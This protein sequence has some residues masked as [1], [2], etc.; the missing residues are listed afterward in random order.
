MIIY[1]IKNRL[2]SK[3]YVGMTKR[4]L[5]QCWRE[6]IRNARVNKDEMLIYSAIRKYGPEAFE[7]S[8]LQ[9]CTTI[10]EMKNAEPRWIEKLG[11]HASLGCGYNMTFG[12]EGISGYRHTEKTKK[13]MSEMRRGKK[14]GPMS[15]ETKRNIS[16][17][18][19]GLGT[20]PRLHVRGWHHSEEARTKISE[21]QYVRVVQYDMSGNYVATYDSMIAAEKATGIMRQGISRC[22]RF[23]RR[24]T[25]GFRFRYLNEQTE[26]QK[27]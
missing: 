9:E 16:K 11:T 8:M 2:N 23:S 10:E 27:E 12:G 26:S 3:A 14:F 7:V 24:S 21:S 17:A 1:L 15:E 6:H 25:K 22:C 18:R 20:G 19:K 5:K 4:S 13:K